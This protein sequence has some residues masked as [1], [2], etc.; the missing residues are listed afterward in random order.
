MIRCLGLL[1]AW[2]ASAAGA[3]AALPAC[4]PDWKVELVATAPDIRHPSVVCVAPDG[5]VFVAEDPMDI[6]APANAMEGRIVCFHP[7]GRRTVFAEKLHAVFGMQYLEGKLYL[8]HNPKFSVFTD[9]GDLAGRRLDLIES[10]HPNPW[11]LG[12]NDHVPA[13]FRLAIY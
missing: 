12:W 10:T 5:R 6:R 4:R 13:N 9:A 11:A 1:F 7:G 2:L 3:L 8:L